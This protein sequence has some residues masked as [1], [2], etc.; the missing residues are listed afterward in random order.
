MPKAAPADSG[1]PLNGHDMKKRILFVILASGL[2][3]GFLGGCAHHDELKTGTLPSDAAAI[4]A[5]PASPT[6]GEPTVS[7]DASEPAGQG[8]PVGRAR[9][10]QEA[11]GTLKRGASPF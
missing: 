4:D 2:A 1:A 8:R 5:A 9:C 6:P 11:Q 3:L 10:Q 7:A